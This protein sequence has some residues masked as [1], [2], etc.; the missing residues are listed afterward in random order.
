MTALAVLIT[1]ATQGIGL[2]IAATFLRAGWRVAINSHLPEDGPKALAALAPLGEVIFLPA[3]LSRPSEA[4]RLVQEARAAFGGLECL[5]SN[6]GTYQDSAFGTLTEAQFDR[7]FNLNVKGMIFAAQAFASGCTGTETS[8]SII[9]TGSSNSFAAEA[10][11]VIY[12]ASKGAVLMLVKSLAASLA[13]RGIRVNGIAPGLIRTPLTAAGLEAA[14]RERYLSHQ[15][16]LGRIGD[17]TEIG[18]AALFLAGQGAGYI[19]GHMLTIDG[20]ILAVQTTWGTEPC[21]TI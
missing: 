20:G 17:P 9:C 5:V 19:T 16:P 8:P 13:K 11:S 4:E 18:P 10:D 21:P 3:D 15:I 2:A 14:G 6:A 12:D 1:G 7:T